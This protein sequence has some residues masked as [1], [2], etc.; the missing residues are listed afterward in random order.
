MMKEIQ[1][2]LEKIDQRG[3]DLT[4]TWKKLGEQPQP[5]AVRE[6]IQQA[7]FELGWIYDELQTILKA[8]QSK[9]S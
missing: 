3:E 6:K 5:Q 2:L 4:F 7:L 8:Q 9:G 1:A